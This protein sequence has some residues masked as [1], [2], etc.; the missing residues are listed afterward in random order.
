MPKALVGFQGDYII[1]KR[2]EIN[3]ALLVI[4]LLIS[5]VIVFTSNHAYTAIIVLLVNLVIAILFFSMTIKV[6]KNKVI[7]YFG[8][9]FLRKEIEISEI[10]ET[11]SYETKWYEGIGIR[12]L[13]DGWLY[14]ASVGKALKLTLFDGKKIYLGCKD[15]EGFQQSL[16]SS[17]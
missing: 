6:I 1:Y 14:N 15:L 16:E 13:K 3:K 9:G 5:V 2:T 4:L 8:L 7:W 12:M 11:S 10:V 17:N